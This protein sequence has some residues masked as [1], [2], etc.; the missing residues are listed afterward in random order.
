MVELC[1]MQIVGRNCAISGGKIIAED[2]GIGCRDCGEVFL[3]ESI[4]GTICPKCGVDMTRTEERFAR[5]KQDA[6]LRK[7]AVG[8]NLYLYVAVVATVLSN[9][10]SLGSSIGFP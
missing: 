3:R 4:E 7:L 5:A 6:E 2:D 10:P 8:R 9:T 1:G